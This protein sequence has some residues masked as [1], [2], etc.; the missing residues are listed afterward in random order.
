M[1]TLKIINAN[2]YIGTEQ[3]YIY[4]VLTDTKS[5][6]TTSDLIKV[7][8]GLISVAYNDNDGTVSF[9]AD[10]KKRLTSSTRVPTAS[11]GVSG[12][13]YELDKKLYGNVESGG[14]LIDNTTKPVLG[15]FYVLTKANGEWIIRQ[16]SKFTASKGE[17]GVD[18]Q[19]ESLSFQTPTVTLEPLYGEHFQSYK[20][21]FFSDN[22]VFENM[23]LDEVLDALIADPAATFPIE[24]D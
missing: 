17:T 22:P 2:P 9:Y 4:N 1:S 5:E 6:Y 23:T 13:S 21:E 19:G 20:R 7:E 24:E 18:T 8:P 16:I 12:D 3:L 11:F 15:C 10:N 14:A